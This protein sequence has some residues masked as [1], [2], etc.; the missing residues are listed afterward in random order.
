MKITRNWT[1]D[2]SLGRTKSSGQSVTRKRKYK[3]TKCHLEEK[4]QVDKVSLRRSNPSGQSHL[5][6]QCQ[7]SSTAS[8][9]VQ[10]DNARNCIL[11][12]GAFN[13][14]Q[15]ASKPKTTNFMCCPKHKGFERQK[16]NKKASKKHSKK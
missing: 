1:T 5:E 9:T 10:F 15:L 11:F 7:K 13:K 2:M 14:S 6:E 8:S 16:V 4:S 3:W 12:Y